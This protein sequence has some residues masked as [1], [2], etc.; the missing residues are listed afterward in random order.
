MVCQRIQC[1][2]TLLW[3][4]LHKCSYAALVA[5]TAPGIS[6]LHGDRLSLYDQ[7]VVK[8][9]HGPVIC[10]IRMK[11]CGLSPWTQQPVVSQE[12]RRMSIVYA[13]FF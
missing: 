3:G 10:C 1:E 12:K 9:Y 8:V 7:I 13:I 11:I 4:F 6:T 5:L 2:L